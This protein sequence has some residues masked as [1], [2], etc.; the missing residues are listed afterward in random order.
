MENVINPNFIA[1]LYYEH[2]PES[3]EAQL[4]RCMETLEKIAKAKDMLEAYKTGCNGNSNVFI[5]RIE[6][7]ERHIKLLQSH[8]NAQV[9]TLEPFV[10]QEQTIIV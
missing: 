6:A 5:L 9:R 7:L 3:R 2:H 8:Y 1:H 4:M 10:N